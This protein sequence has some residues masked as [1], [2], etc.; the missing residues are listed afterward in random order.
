MRL[1]PQPEYE[2]FPYQIL[3]ERVY[4]EVLSKSIQ[5]S[6]QVL[7]KRVYLEL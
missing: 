7:L 2:K 6:Y 5:I 4:L 1:E 3:F